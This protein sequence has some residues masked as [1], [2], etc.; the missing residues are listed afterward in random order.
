MG[1][2]PLPNQLSFHPSLGV[3]K[4]V[5]TTREKTRSQLVFIWHPSFD[6]SFG[7]N[8]WHE[9]LEAKSPDV[10][11]CRS[12]PFSQKGLAVAAAERERATK[13]EALLSSFEGRSWRIRFSYFLS[14]VVLPAKGSCTSVA[15]RQLAPRSNS[16]SFVRV[17]SSEC[18]HSHT[19]LTQ[20]AVSNRSFEELSFN[21][22]ENCFIRVTRVRVMTSCQEENLNSPR[23]AEAHSLW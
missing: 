17:K 12:S 22:E 9:F 20:S 1:A 16:F 13:Y 2:A 21:F 5:E 6:R 18:T 15:G 8:F 10:P 7:L 11:D 23:F 4:T 14:L 19:P 3:A